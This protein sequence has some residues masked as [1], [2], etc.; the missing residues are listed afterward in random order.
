M[1]CVAVALQA[2]LLKDKMTQEEAFNI[3]KSAR[4]TV[5]QIESRRKSLPTFTNK[6]LSESTVAGY[7]AEY[8]R[9]T[10]RATSS[11][12]VISQARLTNSIRTWHRRRAALIYTYIV[13]LKKLLTSQDKIQRNA[14]G[15]TE[16]FAEVRAIK[17]KNSS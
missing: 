2:N 4:Y 3:I 8:K 17:L 13:G 16:W 6:P 14:N 7:R 11:A 15:Q 9:L 5:N 10:K 12:E 1:R